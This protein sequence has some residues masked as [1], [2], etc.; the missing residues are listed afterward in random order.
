VSAADQRAR[1]VA[2][3]RDLAELTRKHG[4]AIGGCGCCDSPFL[5]NLDGEDGGDY[6]ANEHDM[7]GPVTWCTGSKP[8]RGHA[9]AG[10]DGEP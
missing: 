2:F 6:S 5:C 8:V 3:L 10:K 1:N 4:I 7:D 9:F